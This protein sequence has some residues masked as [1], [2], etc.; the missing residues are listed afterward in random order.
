MKYIMSKHP[1]Q[2]VSDKGVSTIYTYIVIRL[3]LAAMKTKFMDRKGFCFFLRMAH[4]LR[5]FL[6]AGL[7][8]V[9]YRQIVLLLLNGLFS[10][11]P[12]GQYVRNAGQCCLNCIISKVL[13]HD[14]TDLHRC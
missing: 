14:S 7:S 5:Y 2:T 9:I 1:P 12:T 10:L 8:A 13:H 4:T 6:G 3:L 11:V